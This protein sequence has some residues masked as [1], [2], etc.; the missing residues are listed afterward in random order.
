M[1]TIFISKFSSSHA[2]TKVVESYPLPDI[3]YELKIFPWGRS[4]TDIEI[5]LLASLVSLSVSELS[6]GTTCVINNLHSFS[7]QSNSGPLCK[8]SR[9]ARRFGVRHGLY[10]GEERLERCRPDSN[11]LDKLYHYRIKLSHLTNFS[12]CITFIFA[13]GGGVY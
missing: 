12:V 7:H 13:L 3:K 8:C 9:R 6:L 4:S 10:A 2:L 1:T 5:T 11:N